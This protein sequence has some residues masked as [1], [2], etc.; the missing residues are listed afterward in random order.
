M[1]RIK[2]YTVL[3]SALV[4]LFMTSC[5]DMDTKP[6]AAFVTSE[7]KEDVYESNPDMVKASVTGITS[8]F[9]IYG[10]SSSV[11]LGSLR[12]SDIGYGSIMLSTDSRGMDFVSE[13]TGYNWFSGGVEFSDN[14]KTSDETYMIWMTIYNQL[15]ATRL[16]TSVIDPATDNEELQFYLAQALTIRAFDYFTLAQLY[17]F[18]YVGHEDALCVPIITEKNADDVAVNGAARATVRAV[19]DTIMSDLNKAV[20]LLE[21]S[22][23]ER[24]DKRYVNKAVAYGLRA[25]VNLTMQNWDAAAADAKKAIDESGATPYTIAQVQ[26]PAFS[27]IEDN[28]WMWGILIAETDRVVTSGIVNFPSHMGSLNYGYASVGAWRRVSEALYNSIPASDV[29]KGWFLDGDKKSANLNPAEQSYIVN[30]AGAPAYTQVKYAPYKGELYTSEN[31]CDIP[32]MRIEEMYLILAEAQAMGGDPA[33]GKTTLENFV[34]TYRNPSYTC[35]AST[36]EGVQDAVWYQ[37]RL[38]LWGEGLSYYDIMRLKKGI[39]RRGAGFQAEYVFNIPA[40]DNILI[41][42]IP[43][44]EEQTNPL[45]SDAD[46]NPA[47]S[48]PSPVTDF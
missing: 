37:R 41:Y 39:D 36:P 35:T 25:R 26:R 27:D 2:K 44:R 3:Y 28:S 8:L 5:V 1:I 19:Y 47:T 42:R 30:T 7:Q 29:R 12:H 31:A 24:D 15:N 46:N 23:V 18:N 32:L 33:T 34:K 6:N 10:N 45:I 43:E 4:A 21:S 40:E 22:S 16:I 11:I 20:E 48:T 14:L 38:E 9:S 13:S 17:Q